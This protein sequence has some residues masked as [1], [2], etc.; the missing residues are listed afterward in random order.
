MLYVHKDIRF[1]ARGG[2]HSGRNLAGGEASGRRKEKRD[3]SMQQRVDAPGHNEQTAKAE[4]LASN[5]TDQSV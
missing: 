1:A 5:R 4:A 2:R 3:K